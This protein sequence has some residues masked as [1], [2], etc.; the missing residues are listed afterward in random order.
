MVNDISMRRKYNISCFRE[1]LQCEG[2][3]INGAIIGIEKD[4][5]IKITE[6][7][8]ERKIKIGD[9]FNL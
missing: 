5:F 7:E 1:V 4:G 6:W 2:M 8:C 3:G 9:R